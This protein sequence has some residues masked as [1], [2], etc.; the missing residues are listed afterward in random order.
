MSPDPVPAGRRMS[1]VESPPV[2]LPGPVT[3]VT[4]VTALRREGETEGARLLAD[5]ESF[6]ARFVAFPSEHARV[7]TVLWAAHARAGR[8]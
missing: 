4:D 6:I 8:L 3:V 2:R 5:V 7:A 1:A